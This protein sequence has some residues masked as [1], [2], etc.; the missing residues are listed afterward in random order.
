MKKAYIVTGYGAT[1]KD[2]WFESVQNTLQGRGIQTKIARLPHPDQP[3]LDD[4][5]EYLRH[6]LIDLDKET[7]I[8]A[9][10]L[11]CITTIRYLIQAHPMHLRGLILVSPFA[12]KLPSLPE[13]DEFTK[14]TIKLRAV[15]ELADIREVIVSTNDSIV[16]PVLSR[17]FAGDIQ[18]GIHTI[19]EAG[20]FLASD[21]YVHHSLV[22]R[23]TIDALK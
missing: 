3:D 20:H 9:H 22:S 18:A 11:G 5:L 16:P 1:D 10:S 7:V 15:I 2:H 4:W 17:T 8:I 13:L 23:L 21:G 6:F 19:K 12:E 14:G